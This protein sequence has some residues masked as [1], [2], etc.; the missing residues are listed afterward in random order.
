MDIVNKIAAIPTGPKGI[1]ASDVPKNMIVIESIEL[2][3][4]PSDH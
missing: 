3:A 2:L 1:F 4:T